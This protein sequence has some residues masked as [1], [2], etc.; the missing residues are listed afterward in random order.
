MKY[1]GLLLKFGW[2]KH[3]E[4]Y[5]LTSGHTHEDIDQMFSTWNVHYWTVGLQSI[6]SMEEFLSWAY[7]SE[8]TRP[9]FHQVQY[10]YS[11]KT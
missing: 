7:K 11:F 1:L 8:E 5:V 2:F 6:Q 10:I 9:T 4:L 3:I